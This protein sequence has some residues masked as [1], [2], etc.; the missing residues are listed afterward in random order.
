MS[1]ILCTRCHGEGEVEIPATLEQPAEWTPCPL[2]GGEGELPEEWEQA[3]DETMPT[4]TCYL[5][6][7]ERPCAYLPM[8][9]WP[10]DQPICLRCFPYWQRRYS[11]ET[12]YRREEE[13]FY[14][15][16]DLAYDLSREG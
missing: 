8:N 7:H 5:C 14:A 11:P 10:D 16:A 13:E 2:C 15:Y 9:N 1:T 6:D 12:E 4:D 3:R